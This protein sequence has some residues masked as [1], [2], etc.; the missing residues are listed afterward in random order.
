MCSINGFNFKNEILIKEMVRATKYRGPDDEGF[1]CDENISLGHARLSIIDLSK[2]ARQ[3][4]WNENGT[5]AVI[6]NGEIYN[7]RELRKELTRKGH[8]FFSNS[9]TEVIIHLYE[10]KG[11]RCLQDLNGVF[12]FAVYDKKCAK[13]FLAR[14]RMG[15]KPLYYYHQNGILIFSSEIKAILRHPISRNIDKEALIHHFRI[16]FTPSP[17]T[18]IK[19]IKKL[20]QAHYLVYRDGKINVRKYWDIE[21]SSDINSKEEAVAGIKNLLKNSVKVQLLS[22]D[23]PVGLFLSGGIDST[24]ILGI[25]SEISSGKIKTYSTGF[26]IEPEKFNQDMIL[27]RETSRHYN[28]DHHELLISGRD[29]SDNL[30]KVIWHMEEPVP[31]PI[32]ISTFLLAQFAKKDVAVVLGGDG[33]DEIFGGYPRYY[34]SKLIDRFQLTPGL[35]RDKMVPYSLL[36]IFL[37]KKDLRVKLNTPSGVSRYL[38]H[39]G[40]K[41]KIL[42]RVLSN[43]LIKGDYTEDLLRKR[44]PEEKFSDRGKY[45]MYLDLS[46]WLPDESLI[47]SDK[48]T[49]AFGLEERVPIL[50][51]RLVEF[52]F[53]I[54]TAYKIKG[55]TTNKWIFREAMKEYIPSHLLNLKKRGWF[56]PAAKWL[57][58]DLKNL[59]YDV[60]SPDYCPDTRE[61]FN[62]SEIRKIL[63]DHITRKEYNLDIIWSIL[64]F[65]IWY[66]NF[67]KNDSIL[68]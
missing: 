8:R 53:N 26:D 57:R 34:Y 27:A 49:M 13:V 55:K 15:I 35:I 38:L 7:Y 24:S 17:F 10:E 47:R 37:N 58:G 33:G 59:A 68:R 46:T 30:E 52:A 48:T 66:K 60:L 9:D 4:L 21:E 42:S 51:H 61:Y 43:N 56:S 45:L 14:D 22:S 19:G 32:Q 2:K 3:P 16:F 5:I 65:Q 1:Y 50:D 62:F 67:V 54:P 23:R 63:D 36:E 29:A 12:S 11:E 39:M 64:T 41:A 6:C 28:T 31:N 44:Y 20:P 25:A 18:L 40:Q